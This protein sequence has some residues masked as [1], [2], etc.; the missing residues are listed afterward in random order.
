MNKATNSLTLH[1]STSVVR[2]PTSD[3]SLLTQIFLIL[4]HACVCVF[5]RVWV[6]ICVG[7]HACPWEGQRFMSG[8]V[9]SHSL[10]RQVFVLNLKLTDLASQL[11]SRALGDRAGLHAHPPFYMDAGDLNS[12]T[13]GKCFIQHSCLFFASSLQFFHSVSWREY[14]KNQ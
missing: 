13:H 5:T 11:V 9:L 10:L 1:L 8:V 3:V 14:T 12:G 2:L 6:H 4:L 7:T